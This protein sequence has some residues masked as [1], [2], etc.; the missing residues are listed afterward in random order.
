MAQRS[1]APKT[2]SPQRQP[3]G[4]PEDARQR[5]EKQDHTRYGMGLASLRCRVL[6]RDSRGIAEH[7]PDH[8]THDTAQKATQ[9][10]D[11]PDSKTAKAFTLDEEAR[12][13]ESDRHSDRSKNTARCRSSHGA[14]IIVRARVSTGDSGGLTVKADKRRKLENAGWRVGDARDFLELTP[15]EAEFV[16]IKLSL[17]RRLR[18]L[19][20]EQNWTQAEFARRVGS[21]Q[22]RVAKM[23]AADPTVSVDL[24]VR[25]L[26]AAGADRRELGRIVA[27]RSR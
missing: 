19:R 24:L 14:A 22:S 8:A 7:D 13:N 20:E 6:S 3:G 11:R 26:L 16:E 1:T 2:S 23:E 18:E 5:D 21:S 17:A 9:Q 25:S 10:E 4:H 12:G 15:G 27:S